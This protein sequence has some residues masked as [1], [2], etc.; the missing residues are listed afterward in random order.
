MV[1]FRDILIIITI[2][3]VGMTSSG[4]AED[5]GPVRPSPTDR[6]PVCGMF[7]SK[8]P[9]FLAAFVFNDD[10]HAFF[11]GAKDL[12]KFNQRPEKFDLSKKPKQ[13]KAIYVTDYY[14]L[15]LIDGLK[16]YYVVGSDIFGPMGNEL[17]PFK[18]EKEAKEFMTDHSGK[19]MLRFNEVTP[20]LIKSL[21]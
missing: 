19:S 7:V 4:Y 10:S 6:C 18:I 11:D 5:K 16:A 17:I 13:I 9:D 3:V 8:Y 1:R 14:S 15:E 20:E 2:L 12:F 21:D